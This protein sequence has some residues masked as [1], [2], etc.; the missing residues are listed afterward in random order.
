[1][2][3]TGADSAENGRQEPGVA[4][5]ESCGMALL[6][7]AVGAV[8][9]VVAL[10]VLIYPMAHT[11]ASPVWESIISWCGAGMIAAG[12][13]AGLA[14]ARKWVVA[15]PVLVVSEAAWSLML[16]NSWEYAIPKGMFVGA[17]AGAILGL[18]LIGLISRRRRFMPVLGALGLVCIAGAL[19]AFTGS[20]HMNAVRMSYLPAVEQVL[21]RDV[22]SDVGPIKWEAESS[23]P[24]FR[25]ESSEPVWRAE[26]QATGHT[27]GHTDSFLYIRVTPERW[28]PGPRSPSDLHGLVLE[29]VTI[30]VTRPD[31]MFK[32][33]F[34]RQVQ[35]GPLTIHGIRYTLNNRGLIAEGVY[36]D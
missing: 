1:V 28:L 24:F 25:A 11:E 12:L 4:A 34:Y 19:S 29:K 6:A 30:S 20:M 8:G 32:P 36:D 2:N 27:T 13:A 22:L 35:K 15:A 23:D 10:F 18:V 5:P 7:A 17:S 31:R 26:F 9:F 21:R 14:P 3:Q 33:G 16:G